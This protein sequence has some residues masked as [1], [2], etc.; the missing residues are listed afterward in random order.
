MTLA[1][2]AGKMGDR[3]KEADGQKEGN[4]EGCGGEIGKIKREVGLSKGW[5][6]ERSG[7]GG[8]ERRKK[9]EE[10]EEV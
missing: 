7:N 9:E 8:M 4:V 6:D 3:K 2:D 1:S 10:E 5:R